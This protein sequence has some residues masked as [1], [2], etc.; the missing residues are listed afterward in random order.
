MRPI[1][2]FDRGAEA[3]PERIAFAGNGVEYTYAQARAESQALAR[4][5]VAAGFRPGD[6]V[7][8]AAAREASGQ[9]A[10]A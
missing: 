6:G 9:R 3:M 1:D 5:M 2:Y 8:V 4:G 10:A 7:P